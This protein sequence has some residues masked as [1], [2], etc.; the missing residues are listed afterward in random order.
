MSNW[1]CKPIVVPA[2][3]G[4]FDVYVGSDYYRMTRKAIEKLGK[5]IAEALQITPPQKLTTNGGW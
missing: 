1:P 3:D 5:D 4:K 2:E